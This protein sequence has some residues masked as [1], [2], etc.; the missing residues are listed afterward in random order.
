MKTKESVL[1]HLLFACLQ[2]IIIILDAAAIHL[3]DSQ[4]GEFLAVVFF[5]FSLSTKL[6][7]LEMLITPLSCITDKLNFSQQ[8]CRI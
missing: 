2:D 4:P 3:F 6:I 1:L 5:V 7:A 8:A